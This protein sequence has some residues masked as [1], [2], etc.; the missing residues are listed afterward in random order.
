[1]IKDTKPNTKKQ[2]IYKWAKF[3]VIHMRCDGFPFLD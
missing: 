3:H 2:E 1:M